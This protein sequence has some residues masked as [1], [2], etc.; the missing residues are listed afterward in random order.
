MS[1]GDGSQYF[2]S[3]FRS[4]SAINREE[5]ARERGDFNTAD[6]ARREAKY[7]DGHLKESVR[8]LLEEKKSS[9]ES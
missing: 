8:K 1:Q 6:I 5:I 9:N 4:L 7:W 3:L 2:V